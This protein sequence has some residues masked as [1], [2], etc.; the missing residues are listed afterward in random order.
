RNVTGVQTCALPIYDDGLILGILLV[1][2]R[3][4]VAELVDAGIRD[5]RVVVVHHRGALEVTGVE[6]LHVKVQ[7]APA[8]VAFGIVEVAIQRASV[9]N[10]RLWRLRAYL[11]ANLEPIGV[12]DDIDKL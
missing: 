10:R 2:L 1:T 5:I 3:V 11:I 9:D 8:Q 12:E 6:Y 7:G 4:E